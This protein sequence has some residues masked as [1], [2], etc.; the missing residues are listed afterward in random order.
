[1]AYA[2][3]NRVP[4]LPEEHQELTQASNIRLTDILPTPDQ[5][6]ILRDQLLVIIQRIL[7]ECVPLFAG[8]NDR[9]VDHIQ[10]EYSQEMSYKSEVVSIIWINIPSVN[11]QTE[12]QPNQ[13]AEQP[14]IIPL[15]GFK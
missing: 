11:S 14:S 13:L 3:K 7:V 1:M 2:A 4:H 10:H 9:V 15:V 5:F 8:C 12:N 6:N